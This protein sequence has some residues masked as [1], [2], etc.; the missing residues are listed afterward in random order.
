MELFYA[1]LQCPNYM[2]I[3]QLEV[4]VS[5]RHPL[6]PSPHPSSFSPAPPSIPAIQCSSPGPCS[7]HPM[8]GW[9]AY[10]GLAARRMDT[11]WRDQGSRWLMTN[12]L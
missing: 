3:T 12:L 1:V 6:L 8:P 5:H 2:H 7:G 9:G 4:H 11:P 10:H